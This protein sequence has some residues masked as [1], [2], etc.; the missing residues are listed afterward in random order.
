MR[1]YPAYFTKQQFPRRLRAAG[2]LL[3]L[4]A[5]LLTGL[6]AC[7]SNAGVFGGG[8]WQVGALQNEQLQV[9][10][11]DPNHLQNV[12]AGDAR[13]GIFVSTDAGETWKGA[14]V[15]LPL[16]LAINALSFDIP[17]K[18][19]FAATSAGLFVSDNSARNWSQVAHTPTD[20]YTALTVDPNSPQVV[21]AATA[22]SGIL[23]SSD[24]G[25]NWTQISAGLPSGAITSL[26]YDPNLKQLWATFADSVYRSSDNGASWQMM[27]N[28]LPAG[29]GI[30][31]VALGAVTAS[32]DNGLI[33]LGTDHG[34][35]RSTDA[36][37][38]WTQDQGDLARLRIAN[39]LIDAT[40]ANVVYV[41]TTLGVL[42]SND[43][44]QTWDAVAAG[45]PSNQPF[46]GL[47]QA[48]TGYSQ[49]LVTGHGVYLYPGTS[50]S[51][52]PSHVISLI[53]ILLFFF[54]LY[55]FFSMR[56]RR[57]FRRPPV[58]VDG[59]PG[60]GEPPAGNA[61]NGHTPAPDGTPHERVDEEKRE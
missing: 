47:A 21:Y 31:V 23:K 46:S 20:A 17:G 3:L 22:H 12:Y 11:V 19:L 15:G 56:R 9:L 29:A 18:R 39:V 34:F 14:S 40:Q 6:T 33:F 24:D 51:S 28:G 13:D 35:F 54:L 5:L 2:S 10:T 8:T 37:Q 41:S 48:G 25:Q 4:L 32:G 49:L 42:R 45:L 1:I 61:L 38:H 36:G 59:T 50:S 27:N 43:N 16:P 53:L 52:N 30:N 7:A 57:P 60:P 58:P 26:V 44:G 55:Y